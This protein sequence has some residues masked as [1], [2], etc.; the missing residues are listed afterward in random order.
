MAFTKEIVVD[1]ITILR[2]GQIWCKEVEH[3]FEDGIFY[4][5]S[6]P[7]RRVFIPGS[8]IEGDQ[9]LKDIAAVVHTPRVIAD[10]QESERQ[11]RLAS[12]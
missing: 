4:N 5:Q 7:H 8:V 3:V 2:D 10:F 12:Q 6:L 1:Q 11:R 9:R